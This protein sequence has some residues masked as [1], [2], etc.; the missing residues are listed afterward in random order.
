MI[1]GQSSFMGANGALTAGSQIGGGTITFSG[2]A[3]NAN[4]TGVTATLSLAGL[5]GTAA[6]VG[7]VFTVVDSGAGNAFV[8]CTV[9]AQSSTTVCTVTIGTVSFSGN[10][11]FATWYLAYA[12]PNSYAGGCYHYLPA[13]KAFSGSAAGLYYAVGVSTV[14]FTV[15][16]NVYDPTTGLMPTIPASPT[17]IVDAGPG[18]YTQTTGADI[19][20]LGNM[21]YGGSMGATGSSIVTNEW[22][23]TVNANAKPTT[24]KLGTVTVHTTALTSLAVVE[25]FFATRNRGTN[26]QVNT[27]GNINIGGTA[28]TGV[29]VYTT[30]DTT[31]N[32]VLYVYANSAVATDSIVLESQTVTISYGA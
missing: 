1:L 5:L 18:A 26:K 23:A 9:T 25:E 28:A 24:T 29:P 19:A 6:D 10:G 21:N 22:F 8:K 32:N 3:P 20:L 14:A 13:G 2:V 31:I 11:A 15:Y 7:R 17:A 4:A 30:I 16:N 12:Y 27:R